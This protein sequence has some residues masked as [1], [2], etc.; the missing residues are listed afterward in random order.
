MTEGIVN[1]V[2]RV[3]D[4]LTLDDLQSVFFNWIERLE[5]VTERE[6]EYYTN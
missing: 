1:A 4:D 5:R 3:W 6:G 2:H